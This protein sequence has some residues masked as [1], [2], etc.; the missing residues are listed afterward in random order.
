M[1][2]KAV[3]IKGQKF[4]RLTAIKFSHKIQARYY[5]EFLCD[6]GNKKI[7]EKSSVIHSRVKSCRCFQKE[8]AKQTGKNYKTHGMTGTRFYFIWNNLVRRCNDKKFINYKIY[9]RRGIK[10][11]WNSFEEFYKDMFPTYK[12]N[13]TI[14][15]I[16][17]NGNYEKSNCVWATQKEQ[18]RNRRNNKLI[19]FKEQTK[20]VSEWAEIMKIKRCTL[21]TRL[22][23]LNWSVEKAL[24]IPVQ[25]HLSH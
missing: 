9:G 16:D 23:K 17:N 13:L 20:C 7:I 6:C 14:E 19:T 11:L 18:Q 3:D 4:N 22:D 8:I 24:T 25:Q 1:A 21:H 12:E 15:R 10:C 2:G 5:W